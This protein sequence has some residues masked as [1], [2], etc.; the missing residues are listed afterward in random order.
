MCPCTKKIR[1]KR[2]FSKIHV[3]FANVLVSFVWLSNIFLII[4]GF[5]PISELAVTI[6]TVYGAFATGGYFALCA[7]RDCSYNKHSGVKT[8]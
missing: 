7:V 2:Q 4:A 8:E 6:A 5:Q 1:R 3:V